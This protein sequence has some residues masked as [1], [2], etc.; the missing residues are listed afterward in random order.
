MNNQSLENFSDISIHE[1]KNYWNARP[2][3]IKH[4]TKPQGTKEYFDEVEKRKF[5]VEPHL[6]TFADFPSVKNKKVM[7]IGCGLGT[8]TINFAKAGAKKVTAI[9]LSDA[10][11]ALAKQRAAVNGMSEVVNFQN[12]N[13]EELSKHIPQEEYDLIFSFGVIHHTPHPENILKEAHQFLSPDGKLKV[14]VYYRYSW[15]VFWILIKYG[16]FQFWKLSKLVAKYSEAQ[17]GCPIT[18]IYSKKEAEKMLESC[19]Y[20]VVDIAVDHIFPYK[21]PEYVKYQYVKEWY[22]RWMPTRLFR[23]LEKTFGWH[24]CLTAVKK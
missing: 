15:K 23:F 4:S 18:Y 16:K 17:T 3:N 11:I 14:M 2:C 6:V 5:Y 21:I 7:E 20:K 1:V 9:D 10:S 22:F 8:T 12:I 19:G 13:A 24:L